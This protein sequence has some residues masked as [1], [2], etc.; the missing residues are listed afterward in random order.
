MSSIERR[1]FI[2]LVGGAA[3]WPI[4]A[5][6][7]KSGNVARI[8]VLGATSATDGDH[9]KRIA[10]LRSALRD[11]GYVEGTNL[12]IEYR[13]AEQNYARLPA[14]ADDLVR[15]NVDVIVTH[16]TPASTA[17]KRA[18]TTVPIVMA[19]IG[20]PIASGVVTSLARP[21]G[22]ITGSSFFSPEIS[23][24]RVE[25]L[26]ETMPP[27]TRVAV[28]L[29]PDNPLTADWQAMEIA[30]QSLK[31]QLQR[32]LVRG[33]SEFESAFDSM[34]REHVEAV[35]MDDDALLVANANAIAALAGKRH[36]LSIGSTELARA[37]GIIGYGVDFIAA[38]RH[39]AMFI[40][41]I[42]KGRN[43]GDIP[44]EQ[45]TKFEF[46]LNLRAAK[47]LGFEMPTPIL[48]RA[49]EVIE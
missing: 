12:I 3:V 22:N 44:I 26:K 45:A 2:A 1:E 46:V 25:L 24:K 18:T 8:G 47:A 15:S 19:I 14:L 49:D 36:L 30:A 29:N 20:D 33:P 41:K 39:A 37:G 31:L 35:A 27:L 48:L 23:A 34:Q 28:L 6:A 10:A 7:Q 17:A 40:D 21:G 9:P 16:G 32:F 4:A 11:L 5:R 13:W 38:Y 43:P 42:L